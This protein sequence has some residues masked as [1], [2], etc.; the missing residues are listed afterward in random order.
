MSPAVLIAVEHDDRLPLPRHPYGPYKDSWELCA[1]AGRGSTGAERHR[2]ATVQRPAR[3]RRRFISA[4]GRV[5]AAAAACATQ[6]TGSATRSRRAATGRF[7]W[8]ATL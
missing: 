2:V 8:A 7:G 5:G 1:R 3:R 6:S 4:T